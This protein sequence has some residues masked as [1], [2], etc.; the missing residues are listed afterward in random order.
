MKVGER[1]LHDAAPYRLAQRWVGICGT[2]GW[3]GD[4]CDS[5]DEADVEG[6]RHVEL[7]KAGDSMSGSPSEVPAPDRAHPPSVS[8]DRE[9]GRL[10]A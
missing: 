6:R 10:S 9:V 5:W 3:A 1:E 2:C 7:V 8:D 4:P